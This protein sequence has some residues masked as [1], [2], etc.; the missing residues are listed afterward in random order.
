M[1]GN[2]EDVEVVVND[3]TAVTASQRQQ[4]AEGGERGEGRERGRREGKERG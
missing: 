1:R 3:N 2:G 4:E